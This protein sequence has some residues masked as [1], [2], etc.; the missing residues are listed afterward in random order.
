MM[1]ISQCRAYFNTPWNE[2]AMCSADG[3]DCF[4]EPL[5]RADAV[6][7]TC[8]VKLDLVTSRHR[9]IARMMMS[10]MMTRKGTKRKKIA[11]QQSLENR[12]KTSRW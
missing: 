12:M 3:D 1:E 5:D 7:V 2:S 11:N 10:L 9:E 8:W 6:G 4:N